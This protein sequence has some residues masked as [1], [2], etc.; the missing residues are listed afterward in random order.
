MLFGA[1]EGSF[2][3]IKSIKHFSNKL[4]KVYNKT[5]ILDPQDGEEEKTD[6]RQETREKPKK[7]KRRKST[8]GGIGETSHIKRLNMDDKNAF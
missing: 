7:Q 3:D 8:R 5:L 2:K 6:D 1:E 4:K